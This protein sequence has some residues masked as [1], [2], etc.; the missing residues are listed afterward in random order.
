M[1]FLSAIEYA[2]RDYKLAVMG[3]GKGDKASNARLLA[4][5]Q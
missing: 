3:Q 1:E 2:E 5:K 4:T